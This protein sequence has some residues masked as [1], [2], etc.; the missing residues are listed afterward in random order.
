MMN[1]KRILFSVLVLIS[2]LSFS[3]KTVDFETIDNLESPVNPDKGFYLLINVIEQRPLIDELLPLFFP[4]DPAIEGILNDT[5][6]IML[7]LQGQSWVVDLMG[8]YQR[9][10]IKLALGSNPQWQKEKYDGQVYYRNSQSQIAVQLKDRN[11]I[12][13]YNQN[14]S[15]Q[16][17]PLSLQNIQGEPYSFRFRAGQNSMIEIQK[18]YPSLNPVLKTLGLSLY[19]PDLTG[20]FPV[21]IRLTGQEGKEKA[22]TALGKLSMLSLIGRKVMEADISMEEGILL[23]S[24]FSLNQD[25]WTGLYRSLLQGVQP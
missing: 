24:H 8:Q 17:Y 7:S 25:E 20:N 11:R 6:W 19:Q 14:L 21:E 16:L 4:E 9:G 22:L 15:N 1:Y 13:L 2:L 12:W 18:H 5:R 3:C 23:F 10:N